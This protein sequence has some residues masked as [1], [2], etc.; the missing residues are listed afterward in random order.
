MKKTIIVTINGIIFHVDEDAYEKLQAY[1]DTLKRYFSTEQGAEIIEDIE[2]RIAELF[3]P[4][5]SEAKQSVNM[6][7]ID[8]II[9][10]LGKPE[11]IATANDE[12]FEYTKESQEKSYRKIHRRL[13]RDRDH[14]VLG[15]VCAGLGAY[16]DV[17][18]VIFRILFIVFL[19]AGG[20]SI[21]LYLILWIVIPAAVTAA[22]KL[23]MH[24]EEV[25]ISNIERAFKKEYQQVKK[26][27]SR[28][29]PQ[30]LQI[31]QNLLRVVWNILRFSLGSFL[32]LFSVC[33]AI[34]A[35]VIIYF[36]NFNSGSFIGENIGSLE[37][38]LNCIISP[39]ST[40]TLIILL[41]CIVT[42]FVAGT[43]YAGL[44]LMIRFYARDRWLVLTL[45]VAW[46]FMVI[47]FAIK[48]SDEIR[49]FNIEQS[50]REVV[51]LNK[52]PNNI[53][54]IDAPPS[55]ANDNEKVRK[56]RNQH[57]DINYVGKQ[58]E[59]YGITK[60]D[61]EKS[62]GNAP[63][64]EI[65]RIA[66]GETRDA[67]LESAKQIKVNVKQNDTLLNV[68]PFFRLPYDQLWRWEEAK[69]I[70][71]LPVGYKV[72]FNENTRYLLENVENVSDYWSEE[73]ADK[74]WTMTADGLKQN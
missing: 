7:D 2:A 12:N 68:D 4:R 9:D 33:I 47:A 27:L 72:H 60:I 11:D 66:R 38:Y 40:E 8:E 53:I 71:R 48:L 20:A 29:Q 24:G 42:L 34:C 63:E 30:G 62:N 5:V 58:K 52:L 51:N 28:I 43:I 46:F 39:G 31:I 67:A 44:K 16:F 19:F 25:T 41:V 61:I 17:D 37:E 14:S 65:E 18:M 74:T 6:Q 49:H 56:M 22:Q 36:H 70:L 26:N 54:Y 73:M 15:G 55:I 45:I 21:L 35:I 13:Y 57:F 1:L 10:I 64:M 59:L 69:V 3:Q 32:V 23:E 50:T